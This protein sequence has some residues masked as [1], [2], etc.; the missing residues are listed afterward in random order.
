M[1][2]QSLVKCAVDGHAGTQTILAT[3]KFMRDNG[4]KALIGGYQKARADFCKK[5][6]NF[7]EFGD[8]WIA[9]IRRVKDKALSWA[10]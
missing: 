1:E 4:I 8:G 3:Q 7:D 9:R 2:L 5:L 10:G 6:H